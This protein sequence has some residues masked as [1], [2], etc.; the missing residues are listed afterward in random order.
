MQ[1]L[2]S[3]GSRLCMVTMMKRSGSGKNWRMHRRRPCRGRSR[4]RFKSKPISM[5][6]LLPETTR[7]LSFRPWKTSKS[8][9]AASTPKSCWKKTSA[10]QLTVS[11]CVSK[12]NN[13]IAS[14]NMLPFPSPVTLSSDFLLPPPP[15]LHLP[16]PLHLTPSTLYLYVKHFNPFYSRT[17][18]YALGP[19]PS[20][21]SSSSSS[22]ASESTYWSF[23]RT[24]ARYSTTTLLP[25]SLMASRGPLAPTK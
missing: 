16:V 9:L 10:L 21:S 6:T 20:S 8:K 12:K 17:G 11:N 7:M 23:L 3:D 18:S 4:P 24:R 1:S 5:P 15:P 22:S 25:K 19:A 14:S 13:V 2:K